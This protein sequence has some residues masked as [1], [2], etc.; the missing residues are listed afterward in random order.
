MPGVSERREAIRELSTVV[1]GQRYRLEVMA[2]IARSH[3]GLVCLTDLADELGVRTSN[4]QKPL[5]SLTDSY[6]IS[7]LP[8]GDSKRRFYRRNDSAAWVFALELVARYDGSD[9]SNGGHTMS[10]NTQRGLGS[11]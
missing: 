2:A 5:T 3:G 8:A 11:V 6:L 7:R 4:I 1:F 10:T 9:D